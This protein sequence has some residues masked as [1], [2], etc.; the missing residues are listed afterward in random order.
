METKK[1]PLEGFDVWIEGASYLGWYPFIKDMLS[2]FNPVIYD[3]IPGA[4]ELER[5]GPHNLVLVRAFYRWN[6][7]PGHDVQEHIIV[8][9]EPT[10]AE[11]AAFVEKFQLNPG[12]V[13]L[14]E[15]YF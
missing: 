10:W 11:K 8:N 4:E 15:I 5:H 9:T 3:H 12:L 6:Y 1:A 13:R 2:A 7:A 14:S